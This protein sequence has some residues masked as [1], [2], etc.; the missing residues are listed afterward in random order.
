MRLLILLTV[1]AFGTYGQP[2]ER[3]FL[4]AQLQTAEEMAEA[5][6]VI[7]SI[8]E[9]RELRVDAG[10]RTLTVRGA[11]GQT[12]LAEW[13][14]A[15][16]DRTGNGP[17]RD[18]VRGDYRPVSGGESVVRVLPFR[19]TAPAA[20]NEMATV[21]RSLLEIPNVFVSQAAGLLVL[22][23]SIGQ[24][25]AAEWALTA[26]E[27]AEG[28]QGTGSYRLAGGADDMIRLIPVRRDLTVES[29]HRGATSVRLAVGIRRLYSYTP[30]RVVAVRG[31]EEMVARAAEMLGKL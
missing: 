27:G 1:A 16:L 21:L 6:T 20:R 13:L 2:V 4:F 10:Q 18:L 3:S 19:T 8:G 23:G 9:I 14:L 15:R 5:A 7:R 31:T 26:L 17:Q 25:D 24:A 29:L 11:L 12:E 22:R 30:G 28:A